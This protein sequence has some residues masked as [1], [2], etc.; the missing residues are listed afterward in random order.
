MTCLALTE[1]FKIKIYKNVFAHYLS[2][3]VSHVTQKYQ[4]RIL[5]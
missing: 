3:T 2:I 1:R 4:K 5:L